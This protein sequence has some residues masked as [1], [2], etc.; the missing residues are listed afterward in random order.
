[1]GKLKTPVNLNELFTLLNTTSYQCLFLK[2]SQS[3]YLYA[4]LNFIQLMGLNTLHQLRS[5]TDLELSSN[6][7]DAKMYRDLDCCVLEESEAL[8]VS[9]TITP[10]RNQPIVKTMQGKLYPLFTED[11][12]ANYILGVVAPES[13]LLRL[14]WDQV[15]Q[16]SPDMLRS[17]LV[18]RSYA[19]QLPFGDIS[20][21]K[22]EILTLIELL[23]GQHAGEISE[24]LQLKQTTIESYLMN[25]KN[26]LG[27]STKSELIHIVTRNN[28]LQQIML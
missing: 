23:K 18:K 9:E 12:R 28:V 16:L 26:K 3:N 27:V 6:V 13:K 24:A 19:I 22:M 10:K 7:K 17:L 5:S 1:M 2:N 8:T 4:N 25:I 21:S 15:F 11:G 20:L 14:D